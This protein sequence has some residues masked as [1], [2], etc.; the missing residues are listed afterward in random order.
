MRRGLN[1]FILKKNIP[2]TVGILMLIMATGTAIFAPYVATHDPLKVKL[3]E[4]LEP[5]SRNH[6][7]GT[8]PW[9]RDILSRI[10]FG[11]RYSLVIG[12]VSIAIS[13]LFGGILGVFG[14]Y[15]SQSKLATMIV[16]IT[17][18]T[19]SFPTLILGAMVAIIFGPG[20]FNTIIALA[21]AFF[22][23]FIRLVRGTTLSMKEEVYIL[24]ARSVGMSD[25]RLLFIHLIPNIISPVVVMAVI[26]ASD[27]ISIEV[28]LSFLGLGVSPPTPSWG[29]ILQDNLSYFQMMPLAAIWPCLAVAWTVQSLNMVGDRFRDILDPKMR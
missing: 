9:G 17:D 27:A 4:R 15:Y 26:W 21:I 1:F 18:I 7:L 5:M 3:S 10:I 23:R 6:F 14:G 29:T 16:W 28:A 22:P 12:V 2:L 19:M 24:A 20:V 13:M 11:T 25:L 8:D